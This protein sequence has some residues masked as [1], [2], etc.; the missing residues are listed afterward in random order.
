MITGASTGIGEAC[1][2]RLDGMGLRVFAG[3]RKDADG[4]ALRQ[5]A[6]ERL[7]PVRIDVTNVAS[8]AAAAD[9]V[10][11]ATGGRLW[12]LVNNAGIGIGGPLEFLAI[13]ELRRQLEVNLIGQVAVTQAFLPMVRE[14][15][16]RI[17]NMGS[18]GGRMA[19]PFVGPYNA[20]KFG[21]EAI[22]D[23]LRVELM[24]WGIGVAIVEP[25]NIATPIWDKSK[26]TL[27]TIQRDL[28]PRALELYE[29]AIDAMGAYL[30][31]AA[32]RGIPPDRV[33]KAVAHALTSKRPKTRYL[34]GTDAHLQAIIATW[35]PDRLV[36]RL[37][38]RFTKLPSK[39]PVASPAERE[40]A[41]VSGR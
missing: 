37:T 27:T 14:T 40:E 11:G 3:V 21:M 10:R 13:D 5:K 22:T 23:A 24:P 36:D 28:P 16:G 7:T 19:S 1:A 41:A 31:D 8:I 12:G 32:K 39:A 38:L 15:R 29:P 33:A 6:S 4:D 20:S 9:T 34:V 25:G 17:V 2:L 35:L 26:A 30:E 18:I